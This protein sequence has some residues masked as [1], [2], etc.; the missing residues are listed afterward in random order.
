MIPSSLSFRYL[1]L[2]NA[3]GADDGHPRVRVNLEAQI[4]SQGKDKEDD[5]ETKRDQQN[6]HGHSESSKIQATVCPYS[7]TAMISCNAPPAE[8]TKMIFLPILRNFSLNYACFPGV[9]Q[10]FRDFN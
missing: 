9:Y 8:Y 10:S 5:Q 7:L 3:V 6:E 1:T 4:L 2:T